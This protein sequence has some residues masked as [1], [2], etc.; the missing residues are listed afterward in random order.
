[1]SVCDSLV[2]NSQHSLRQLQEIGIDTANVHVIYNCVPERLTP[3]HSD[4]PKIHAGR[5][6]IVYLGRIRPSKGLRE[7]FDVALQLITERNNV[8]F[9]LA[10]EYQWRNPFADALIEEVR[11]QNLGPRIRF[12]GQIEDV[13]GLLAQC[14]LHVLP[15]IGA[16]ESFSNAVLEA[17][18]QGIP[19]VVFATGGLPEA[20]THLVDGYVCRQKSA[21]ALYEGIQYFLNNP[22][23][24]KT[25]GIA[26]K[27]SLARFSREAAG[28]LWADLFKSV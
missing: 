18:S 4:A 17:K 15:S 21:K 14:Q 6:N 9:Y 23:A 28:D 10:G 26:A 25:A 3:K 20:V 12:T 27:R 8:D 22:D 13:S 5:F 16:G 7:L 2:C 24:L 11:A 1:M 19:S